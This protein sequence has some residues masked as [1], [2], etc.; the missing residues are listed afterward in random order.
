MAENGQP[1]IGINGFGRIGRLFARQVWLK[2]S[3]QIVAINDP[4]LDA[5]AMV[6]L[7]K[8][9]SV[10]GKFS[11]NI[12]AD[13]KDAIRVNE[14]RIPIYACR[15]AAQIPWGACGAVYIAETSGH[16]T[17]RDKAVLHLQG[18]AQKVIISAPAN[19]ETI[20]TFVMGVN[21]CCYCPDMSVVS[22]AS[23]TTNCMAPLAKILH[24]NFGIEEGLMSSIHAVTASQSCVDGAS[25]KDYRT[26][27]C[28]TRN[29]IPTSTGAAEAVVK[30]IP[31]LK[32]K[33]TGMAFRVPVEN[34]SV[35]DLTCRLHSPMNSIDDLCAILTNIE[36]DS[37]HP[38]H[39]VIT[40]AREPVVS[41]D[42]NGDEHS[43]IVDIG[44]CILLNPTFVKIIAYYDNEW[45]Y[46]TRL[47]SRLHCTYQ[48][49]YGTYESIL[50]ID[51][52]RWTSS[53]ACSR[54]TKQRTIPGSSIASIQTQA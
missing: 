36:R 33:L 18:G 49:R 7:V 48:T 25:K 1:K 43:C 50:S 14:V 41:S 20:P 5:D 45:G 42:F 47:V 4:L 22:N 9:D 23:C 39:S 6:Y 34:V 10:H 35:L 12:E 2:N 11:I 3:A 54:Q 44:A 15:E 28:F 53:S 51:I 30:V 52:N 46:A 17:T 16:Y 8:Y 38:L 31:D 13:G 40:C 29:I 26:G 19:D 32:G 27:R 24:E 21:E 37:N